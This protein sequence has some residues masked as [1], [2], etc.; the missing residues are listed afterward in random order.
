MSQYV[1]CM[2]PLSSDGSSDEE[3]VTTVET[4]HDLTVTSNM[5]YNLTIR[6]DVCGGDVMENES[7]PDT[8]FAISSLS[9]TVYIV[10]CYHDGLCGGA[11]ESDTNRETQMEYQRV[12]YE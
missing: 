11:D 9:I 12:S 6:A 4:Q 1:L 10:R 7:E 2:T 3:C 8:L 5:R